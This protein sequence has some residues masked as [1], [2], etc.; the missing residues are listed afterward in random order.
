MRYHSHKEKIEIT[1]RKWSSDFALSVVIVFLPFL[2][3]FWALP[4]ISGITIGN[5]YPRFSIDEQIQLMFSIKTGSF[6]LYIPGYAGGQSASALTLGQLFHPISHLTSLMP[7]YWSGKA[8]EWN[9]LFRLFTLGVAQLLLFYL[10]KKF[11]IN[12]LWAFIFSFITVYNLRMLDLFR[13]GASLESWT[14]YLFLCSAIGFYH[15]KPSQWKGPVFIICAT[16]WLVCSGH[17]QMMYYGLLGAGLF[18]LVIPFF[19]RVMLTESNPDVRSIYRFWLR[20]AI[21]AT[22]GLLLSSAY[23]LPFYFDFILSNAHRVTQNYAWADM[24]RDTLMG[25]V[26]NF[27]QPLRSDVTGVFGGSSLILTVALLPLLRLLRVKVPFVVWAIWGVLVVAFLHMQGGRTPVHFLAWKFLPMASAFRVAGRISLIMPVFFMLVLTWLA[28]AE[29]IRLKIINRQFELFPRTLL[30]VA[31]LIFIGGYLLFP[32][33]IVRNTTIYSA[34]SIR[35]IP[36]QV[37]FA[38]IF[39]GAF[40]LLL[41]A[42]YGYHKKLRDTSLL[43]LF[44]FSCAQTILLLPYG[45]WIEEKKDTPQLSHLYADMRESLKYRLA[46]GAFMANSTIIRQVRQSFLEP[47]LGRTYSRWRIAADNEQAYALMQQDRAPDEIIIEHNTPLS[48]PIARPSGHEKS[49][50]G[51][52]MIYSS[53][54]RLVFEVRVTDAGFFS[55]AYPF[56]GHWK[57]SVNNKPVRVYRA[58]G[59]YHAVAIPAGISRVEFRY[60]S[61]AVFWGMIISCATLVLIGVFF[62]LRVLRYP[63][64]IPVMIGLLVVVSAGFMIWHQSLYNGED[65]Q[66]SYIW[67]ESSASINPNYAYGKRTIMSSFI[68]PNFIYYKSSGRAVDGIRTPASGFVSGFQTRPWWVVDLH[69]LKSFGEIVIYEGIDK[70]EINLRPLTVAI[71]SEGKRWRTVKTLTDNNHDSPLRILFN[72]PQ[73]A[74]YVMIQASGTCYLSLDEVEIYP[75]KK[76]GFLKK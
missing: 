37:E 12:I 68:F 58:N 6:P 43:L 72:E 34:V 42:V 40:S 2:M 69:Q 56:T 41:F 33:S 11:K 19:T 61:T 57:A 27:F 17:P 51:V 64:S 8:L 53:F 45:T 75:A 1:A 35:E 71:S 5:D 54:N 67:T 59:A 20:T 26:N 29:A 66:T 76:V 21:F 14:G 23:T 9:T 65:L 36:G 25:T 10:L 7:G 52:K 28:S 13:Y 15:L 48:E 50:G 38:A 44:L 30:A 4:F 74:R 39:C 70:P 63:A 31:A 3:F 16:Y 32:D 55:L 62:S 47:F 46:T 22:V 73:K 49:P 60:G 24:Y 18:T